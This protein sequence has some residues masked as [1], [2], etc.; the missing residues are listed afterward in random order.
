VQTED[1]SVSQLIDRRVWESIPLETRSQNELIN[2]VAGA[3]PEIF[4][5]TG[6]GAAVNGARTGTGNYLIE[7]ADN[8]DQGLGGAA[9]LG[10]GGANTTISPDAIQE[11]RVITNDF[12]AEYG[13]AGG[14]VT[15]TVLKS[16]T[17]QVHGSAF[18]YNRIQA[19]AANDFSNRAHQIDHLV[20]NQFGGSLGGPIT[21]DRTFFYATGELHRLRQASPTTADGTTPVF[22]NFVGSGAFEKFMESDPNGYCVMN[23]GAAC[24]GAFNHSATLGPIF[25]QLQ[26]QEPGSFP[27]APVTT[28]CS[29]VAG[30]AVNNP[31]CLAHCFHRN[32]VWIQATGIPNKEPQSP[33][34]VDIIPDLACWN[35][36]MAAPA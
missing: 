21:K 19:L 18:E 2:L 23:L 6:R 30:P 5:G 10:P 15:D 24:P 28:T 26:A 16:G 3:E 29:P 14:F 32:S 1:S 31:N 11:Y 36:L 9:L 35:F 27:L 4:A 13:K 33:E 34:S 12:P 25:Q 17:N 20:R 22:V 7:G 8:N